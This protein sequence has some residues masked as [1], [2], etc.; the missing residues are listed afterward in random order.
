MKALRTPLRSPARRA[1]LARLLGAAALL[2]PLGAWAEERAERTRA[3]IAALLGDRTPEE[4]GIR[5][6]APE[7]AE[8]GNTVPVAVAVDPPDGDTF[9][10]AVHLFAE[11]NPQP[12]V[13]SFFFT[14]A[15]GRAS[16]ST[17]IRLAKTQRV[18]AVAELSDGRALRASREVKVTIGG[19]G[20]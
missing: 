7:I 14:R 9:V 16:A 18:I 10:E 20:G 1:L 5:L 19:C 17:R 15:S 2:S 13:A 6:K 12:E 11:E 4:G 8:N 3:A